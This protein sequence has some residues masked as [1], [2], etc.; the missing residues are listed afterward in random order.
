MGHFA[1]FLRQ[2]FVVIGPRGMRIE[3][4]I[5]LIFPAE[6]EA[7]FRHGVVADLR[8][9]MAFSQIGCVRGDLVGNQ[10]LLNI[11]FIRQARCSFGVT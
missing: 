10:P 6:L 5:K 3:C 1:G 9:G 2:G 7:S 8:A 11:L 4:Q